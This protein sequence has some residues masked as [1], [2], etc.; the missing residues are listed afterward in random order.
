MAEYSD[1]ESSGDGDERYSYNSFRDPG[2]SHRAAGDDSEDDDMYSYSNAVSTALKAPTTSGRNG[3][4]SHDFHHSEKY[5]ESPFRRGRDDDDDDDD[6]DAEEMIEFDHRPPHERSGT[7]R[8]NQ[9][10]YDVLEMASN[11]LRQESGF[12]VGGHDSS[13]DEGEFDPKE[14][15]VIIINVHLSSLH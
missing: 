13:G 3:A 8:A 11:R 10:Y 1:D 14:E 6:D 9:E 2:K 7:P 15:K 5:S 12:V 4:T